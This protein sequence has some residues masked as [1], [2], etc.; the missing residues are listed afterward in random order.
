MEV[1]KINSLQGKTAI[2]TGGGGVL[3]SEFAKILAAKG[4]NVALLNRNIE[5]TIEIS[6]EINSS[7]G[8]AIAIS[9]DVLDKNSLIKAK[10]KIN[11]VFG[12][13][14]ILINGAGG[15]NP[16]G[17]TRKEYYETGD[18]EREDIISFFNL[19]SESVKN[20]MDLN[21][22]GTLI[23]SQVFAE[24]MLSREGCTIINISSMTAFR[25]LTKIPAYSA[26]K[27]AVSNLTM[28]MAIHFANVGIRV[29]AI[30]P[31][32]FVT[33]QNYSLL[34]DENENL[35]DRAK[36]I[37]NHTP[38]GRFGKPSDLNGTLLWLADNS[39]SGFVTGVIIPVDG[40]FSAY[41][42]I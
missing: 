19:D 3:C 16:K 6:D 2:I 8:K 26:A 31:G 38:M 24:D 11:I 4:V 1:S 18:E 13:C 10:E 36:K 30:A 39:A 12:K 37:I 42:G 15:N 20:V 27:S 40:G 33:K 17:T 34:Y 14:D 29:N 21:F 23:P 5:K 28:W 35:S 32:F 25:P 41:S 22:T 9:A 7:G